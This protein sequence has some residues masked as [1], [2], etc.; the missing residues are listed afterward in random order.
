M[1]CA[2][3]L[4]VTAVAL[5]SSALSLMVPQ[6]T[7]AQQY[8]SQQVTIIVAAAAGGFAD[9]V[10][11]SV[12]EKLSERLGQT[13]VVENKAGA[14]GNLGARIVAQSRPDGHTVLVSTTSMAIN[15]TLYKN[16]GYATTDIRP[17]AIVGSAPE[18][19]VVHPSHPAQESR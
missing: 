13:V 10:A 7:A 14:G 9:G 15:G 4:K 16:M 11:R 1:F 18:A 5:S 19:I 17:V 8:P 3:R 6:P 2:F 12:G